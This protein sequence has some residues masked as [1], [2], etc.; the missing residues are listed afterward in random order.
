MF[1]VR[2]VVVLFTVLFVASCHQGWQTP[3]EQKAMLEAEG[4]QVATFNVNADKPSE[5]LMKGVL[6]SNTLNDLVA[7]LEANPQIET[8]VMIEVPGSIDDDVNLLAAREIRLR[9]INTHVPEGG[10]V[11]SGGT[12]LFVS[13]V[14]RSAH[15]SAKFGVHAWGDGHMSANDFAPSDQVHKIYTDYYQDMGIPSAFYWFTLEAAPVDGMH[16][17]SHSQL[18][19]YQLINT[20]E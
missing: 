17:M 14:R 1:E 18:R 15:P 12:D 3:E 16:W 9:G 13:G 6:Y 4:D 11:A 20:V 19:R 8:L 10:W 7:V 2:F 5:L